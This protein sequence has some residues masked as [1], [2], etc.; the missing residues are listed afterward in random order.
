ML[1]WVQNNQGRIEQFA[2]GLTAPAASVL[3]GVASDRRFPRNTWRSVQPTSG[4]SATA[5]KAPTTIQVSTCRT[6]RTR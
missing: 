6:W 1:D 2:R 4:P 3:S 5:K